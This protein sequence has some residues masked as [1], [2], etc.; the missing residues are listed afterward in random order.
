MTPQEQ[1]LLQDFLTQLVAVKGV[2]KDAEADALIAQAVAQ[3]PDAA[4]LLVQRALLLG[5]AVNA[6]QAQIDRL[7]TEAREAATKKP[8]QPAA[9]FLDAS[10]WGRKPATTTQSSLVGSSA[11]PAVSLTG[12]PL[13]RPA[14]AATPTAMSAAPPAGRSNFL[15]NAAA[16]AAGVVG[17][18]FLFQGINN[19]MNGGAK[20]PPNAP[21]PQAAAEPAA[22]PAS[23]LAS[24]SAAPPPEELAD[25][26]AAYDRDMDDAGGDDDSS[27]A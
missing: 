7:E 20:T 27:Y 25:N 8:A 16:A 2:P 23:Q 4:Y 18:A 14:S 15:G 10:A 21:A 22:E 19:L 24:E 13:S 11:P 12:A 26:S 1:Q 6:A 9:T 5:E 3:Q 17:G